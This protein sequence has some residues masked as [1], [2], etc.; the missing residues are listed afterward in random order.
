MSDIIF[1]YTGAAAWTIIGIAFLIAV[2]W[3]LLAT[4]KQARDFK[5]VWRL[6]GAP[7]DLRLQVLAGCTELPKYPELAK[8][9]IKAAKAMERV[10]FFVDLREQAQSRHEFQCGTDCLYNG[11]KLHIIGMRRRG[12]VWESGWKVYTLKDSDGTVY[13][14]VPAC[15]L[16]PIEKVK[17]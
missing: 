5:A 2:V 11:N 12:S 15:D 1:W 7:E 13:V 4:Y 17:D 8:D 3:G 9:L 16:E 6:F 10:Q 14:D